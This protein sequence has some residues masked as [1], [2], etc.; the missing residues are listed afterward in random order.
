MKKDEFVSIVMPNG[1]VIKATCVTAV[2][3]NERGEW[4]NMLWGR[5]SLADIAMSAVMSADMYDRASDELI[6]EMQK[7]LSAEFPV[8]YEG[9]IKSPKIPDDAVSDKFG[10]RFWKV[11]DT[12]DRGETGSGDSTDVSDWVKWQMEQ[13]KNWTKDRDGGDED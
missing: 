13:T 6:D 5:Y 9:D 7:H 4:V 10:M 8:D 1:V 12:D 3:Q 2:M 11:G